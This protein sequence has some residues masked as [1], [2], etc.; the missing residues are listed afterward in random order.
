MKKA[1]Y[2]LAFGTMLSA[3]CAYASTASPVVQAVAP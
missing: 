2:A 1:M 3:L